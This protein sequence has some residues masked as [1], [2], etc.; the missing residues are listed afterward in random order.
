MG[1]AAAEVAQ[2]GASA[3]EHRDLHRRGFHRLPLLAMCPI[4]SA[5][6]IA[7]AVI[8][9]DG[10][11]PPA[12]GNTEPS[13]TKR[14]GMS[15]LRQSALTTLS[16][17]VN[18]MRAVPARVV[19]VVVLPPDVLGADQLKTCAHLIERMA[20][21][22][23]IVVAPRIGDARECAARIDRYHRPASPDC[24]RS[25][26]ARRPSSARPGDCSAASPRAARRPKAPW[27][28]S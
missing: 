11:T 8:V 24:S 13:Q 1:P 28:R 6:R 19:H 20:D 2:I 26:V 15:Q 7:I 27:S 23:F 16:F 4:R 10:F 5:V 21:H 25:V 17:G 3:R 14:F 12:V 22:C 18:P 9:N